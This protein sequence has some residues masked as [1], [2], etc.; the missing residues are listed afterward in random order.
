MPK[1]EN[2]W[3]VIEDQSDKQ[4]TV[5]RLAGSNVPLRV[6]RDAARLLAYVA[7]RF[8]KEVLPLKKNNKPG[9]QDDGGYNLR[10]IDGS[11]T[12]SN[13]ASGT[14]IDLN[15]QSFPMFKRKMTNKQV[16]ACRA[17]VADCEGLITWGGDYRPSRVDQMH[18][19]VSKGVTA[20]EIKKFVARLKVGADG[21]V[22]IGG[23]A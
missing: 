11:S 18:F 7:V 14:A 23:G 21:S 13:H 16:E 5:V 22:P 2:G 1:T 9:F 8:D 4:L 15:W 20:A 17:I 12:Y 19:E 10:K 3:N 6:H